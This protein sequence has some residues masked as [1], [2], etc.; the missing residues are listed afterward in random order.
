MMFGTSVIL[1]SD[2]NLTSFE[3]QTLFFYS[4]ADMIYICF[5]IFLFLIFRC[6][7]SREYLVIRLVLKKN[8]WYQNMLFIPFLLDIC[9]PNRVYVYN[10]IPGSLTFLIYMLLMVF[11]WLEM[12][13]L[14]WFFVL[15]FFFLCVNS[16]LIGYSLGMKNGNIN[17][18]YSK[19]IFNNNRRLQRKF[20]ELF[21]GNPHSLGVRRAWQL[22]TTGSGAGAMMYARHIENKEVS[23]KQMKAFKMHSKNV[24]EGKMTPEQSLALKKASDQDVF[25]QE[26]SGLNHAVSFATGRYKTWRDEFSKPIVIKEVPNEATGY[27]A[28]TAEE[29]VGHFKKEVKSFDI[30]DVE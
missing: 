27:K 12:N 23:A 7:Y 18:F 17:S 20:V 21:F 2:Q 14:L 22:L 9:I 24:G 8:L 28:A 5:S 6:L 30:E 1:W 26:A 25:D 19:Y 15:A 4:I 29:A 16:A 11:G 13:V 10:K 3:T